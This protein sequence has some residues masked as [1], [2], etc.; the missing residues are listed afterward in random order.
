MSTQQKR[1]D[2]TLPSFFNIKFTK[3]NYQGGKSL[4]DQVSLTQIL[5]AVLSPIAETQYS[6]LN[7]SL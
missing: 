3:G 6:A 4:I 5:L 7:T 2:A 1:Q